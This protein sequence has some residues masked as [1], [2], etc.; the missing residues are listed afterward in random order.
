MKRFRFSLRPVHVIRAQRELQAREA[1]AAA[2]QVL[3]QAEEKL[4]RIRDRKTEFETALL[5]GRRDRFNAANAAQALVAY[6]QE[7]L[8]E[9]EADRA[10]AV[11]RTGVAE[12][13]TAYFEAHSRL[14]VVKRLEVKARGAHRLAALRSEQIELD[15]FAGRTA[16]R[17]LFPT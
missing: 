8:A 4:T 11:A 12:R 9:A 1:L 16:S 7:C 15:E 13:R 3:V 17:K 6:R 5:S 10:T 14:E 2:V